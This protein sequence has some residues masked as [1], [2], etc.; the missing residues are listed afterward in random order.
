VYEF[1]PVGANVKRVNRIGFTGT[2]TTS[3][4]AASF[5]GT[6]GWQGM[7]GAMMID[8]Y[9]YYG[10][11]TG[12]FFRREF[13]GAELKPI[14]RINP[15]HDPV[16]ANVQTGSDQTYRGKLPN[17]YAEIPFISAMFYTGGR[18]YYT[19]SDRTKLYW[20]SFSVDS[21]VIAPTSHIV[22]TSTVN[23]STTQ[24]VF[25]ANG[26]VYLANRNTGALS[27]IAFNDGAVDGVRTALPDA[28]IGW[29]ARGLVVFNP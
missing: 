11:A 14:Q 17:F 15:Y 20:R 10:S 13:T 27:R 3:R 29:N 23:W 5:S 21:G 9:L 28:G 2:Q 8:D 6:V 24:G 19:R 26:W 25:L 16:W 4:A 7:R 22:E 1:A 12:K 18:L